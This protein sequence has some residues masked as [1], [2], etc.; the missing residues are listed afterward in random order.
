MTR[1]GWKL[2]DIVPFVDAVTLNDRE[3]ERSVLRY[4]RSVTEKMV[5][6]GIGL[7]AE[8]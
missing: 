6:S 1:P 5:P 4:A 7:A 3:R 8:R 2:E